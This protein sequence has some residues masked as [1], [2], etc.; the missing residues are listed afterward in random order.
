MIGVLVSFGAGVAGI[1]ALFRATR[2]R[3]VASKPM[4]IPSGAKTALTEATDATCALSLCAIE[5]FL[6]SVH[7]ATSST[8]GAIEATVAVAALAVVGAVWA[9]NATVKVLGPLGLIAFLATT[10]VP[11]QPVA[12][13]AFLCLTCGF[14]LT[15]RLLRRWA[16]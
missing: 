16:V 14:L 3:G 1:V 11:G 7:L 4:R 12:R 8:A 6:A 15:C 5:R 9:A 10:F 2:Q 13:G